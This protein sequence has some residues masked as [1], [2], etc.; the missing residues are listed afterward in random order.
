MSF[1][2]GPIWSGAARRLLLPLAGVVAV[3]VP[4]SAQQGQ[5]KVF[6]ADDYARA[7]RT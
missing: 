4:L 1:R 3:A 7:E 5:G 6:T 2:S